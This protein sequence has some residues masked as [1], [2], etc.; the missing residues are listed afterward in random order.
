M[1]FFLTCKE[2]IYMVHN[3]ISLSMFQLVPSS[4][5]GLFGQETSYGVW[6]G[7]SNPIVL[8]FGKLSKN[9]AWICKKVLLLENIA[10]LYL[11]SLLTW[12]HFT[13]LGCL[14]IEKR[15][16]ESL[17]LVGDCCGG[18]D[19]PGQFPSGTEVKVDELDFWGH[20]QQVTA[21]KWLRRMLTWGGMFI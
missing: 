10:H 2:V 6:L 4:H 16:R 1:E 5:P 18:E 15:R 9:G 11:H 7:D 3:H 12:F 13:P 20:L 14:W 17:V 19:E 8:Q 21:H